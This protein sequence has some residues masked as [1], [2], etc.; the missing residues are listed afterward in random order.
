MFTTDD[1]NELKRFKLIINQGDYK[2]KGEAAIMVANS[3]I[4]FSSLEKKINEAIEAQGK[5][6][7]SKIKKDPIKKA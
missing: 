6:S 1:L 7:S 5:L 4:W 3:F 2:I